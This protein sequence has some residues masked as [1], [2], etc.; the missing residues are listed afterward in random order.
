MI[1]GV[2]GL[3]H[4]MKSPGAQAD[5]QRQ[6]CGTAQEPRRLTQAVQGRKQQAGDHEIA[7]GQQGR[8][9]Q[10]VRGPGGNATGGPDGRPNQNQTMG[11][12]KVHDGYART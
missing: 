7:P 2:S 9:Q 4:G 3:G 12:E 8:R 11:E 5:E 6:D 10:P 1:R